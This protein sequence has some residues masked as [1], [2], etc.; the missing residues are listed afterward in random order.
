M[1]VGVGSFWG[2]SKD[3]SIYKVLYSEKLNWDRRS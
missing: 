3:H 2:I 1:L